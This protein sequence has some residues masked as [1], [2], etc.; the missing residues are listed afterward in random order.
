MAVRFGP[1]HGD[2][3]ARSPNRAFSQYQTRNNEE[4]FFYE[5]FQTDGTIPER[6]T[7]LNVLLNTA[8]AIE[9]AEPN[10]VFSMIMDADVN[11]EDA[12]IYMNNSLMFDVN[13]ALFFEAR[14]SIEVLPTLT[15]ELVIGMAGTHN[16]DKDTI[17]VSSWF[18][19]DGGAALVVESDDTTNDN[20]DI[21]TGETVVAAAWH[22]YQIDF[23]NLA[24]V[25]YY[26]DG[27]R[28]APATTFD[29]TNLTAAEAVMQPYIGLDKTADAGLGTIFI[30][31]IKIW[32]GRNTT[33]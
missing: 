4:L 22:I 6:W 12:L 1:R 32:S 8:P 16:L 5:E 23:S 31:Y 30:D 21:A 11:A 14:V 29:M 25:R 9:S 18:K 10:G 3:A 26:Y 2:K 17:N 7:I 33:G 20:N 19:L 15:A 24:N 13:S 28:M 27:V